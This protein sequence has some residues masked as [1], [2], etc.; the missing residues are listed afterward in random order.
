MA[1]A[2][3]YNLALILPAIIA[4]I[5]FARYKKYKYLIDCIMCILNIPLLSVIPYWAYIVTILT[6]YINMR[7]I[8]AVIDNIESIKK[9]PG[10]L[11]IKSAL[12]GLSDGIIFTSPFGRITY[13]NR[14]MKDVLYTL[15]ISSHTRVSNIVDAIQ[16]HAMSNGRCVSDNT[17]I[18]DTDTRSYRFTIDKSMSQII[19]FDATQEEK[20]LKEFDTSNSLLQQ[21]NA[22][23]TDNLAQIDQITKEQELLNMK[24]HIHDNLAQQLSIVH[25]VIL[26]NKTTNLKDIKEMLRH[27]ETTP[28]PENTKVD[29]TNITRL[30]KD[31]GIKLDINVTNIDNGDIMILINKFIKET[32]TNAIRHGKASKI[33]ISTSIKNGQYILHTSNNG[34]VPQ[35][36]EYGNGLSSLLLNVKKLN[37][38]MN[39]TTDGVFEI[40]VTLPI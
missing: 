37:G 26:N 31:I 2:E 13:I 12:D 10:K 4:L 17:Y 28:D 19:S 7:A 1:I 36:I 18:V 3:Y 23:L 14:A 16:A 33:T 8:I 39:I 5:L 32:T 38:K 20:L 24:G 22:K 27:I 35:T 21:A 9:Y 29:Y 30:M 40:T 6:L 11:A 34:I 25:M 15:N